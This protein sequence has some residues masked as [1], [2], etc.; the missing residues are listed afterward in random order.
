MTSNKIPPE[1]TDGI[2]DQLCD[3]SESLRACSQVCR[4][5]LSRAR[6]HLFFS[7]YL[8]K[9]VDIINFHCLLLRS[10]SIGD[11]VQ[12]LGLGPFA[13]S[14]TLYESTQ[15]AIMVPSIE[16]QLLPF[17]LS[18]IP[19]MKQ[20]ED[21]RCIM[22]LNLDPSTIF[23]N[24]VPHFRH[25]TCF[26][27]RLTVPSLDAFSVFIRSFPSLENL[28]V[29]RL[30]WPSGQSV[31][32]DLPRLS[33]PPNLKA[34]RCLHVSDDAM[35]IHLLLSLRLHS[36]LETLHY[37]FNSPYPVGCAALNTLLVSTGRLQFL[38]I[39]FR[40]PYHWPLS[41]TCKNFCF[42]L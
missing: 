8:E 41:G 31:I 11:H 28:I 21:Y 34:I 33:S 12:Q 37:V 6:Y 35:F 16:T 39:T 17:I 32:A 5:F 19:N 30:A 4:Q 3:H 36:H 26:Q 27:V 1:I 20:F 23:K 2:I 29:D 15:G 18:C 24:S 25:V 22:N 10:P 40:R 14:Q 13:H 7:I 42:G 9:P 38:N